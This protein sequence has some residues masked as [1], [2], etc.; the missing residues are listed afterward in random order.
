MRVVMLTCVCEV[1]GCTC[2]LLVG[3]SV[4]CGCLLVWVSACGVRVSVRVVCL[5]LACDGMRV[6]TLGWWCWCVPTCVL[7]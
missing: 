5:V 4:V 3:V 2:C 7:V 1:L 6:F